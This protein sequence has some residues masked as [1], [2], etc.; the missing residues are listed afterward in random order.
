[1]LPLCPPLN[2]YVFLIPACT[3]SLQ[4]H[5]KHSGSSTPERLLILHAQFL[6]AEAFFR[7]FKSRNLVYTIIRSTTTRNAHARCAVSR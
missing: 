2:A 1:M 4:P 5:L 6:I 7:R 3:N